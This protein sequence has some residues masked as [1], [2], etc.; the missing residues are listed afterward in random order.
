[1]DY[2]LMQ[3]FDYEKNRYSFWEVNPEFKFTEPFDDYY[4]ATENKDFSSEVMW[5]IFLFCDI[6]SPKIRLRKDE[7]EED[8]KKYFLKDDTFSFEYHQDLID[9]YPKVVMT[10][11]QRELKVWQ[12]K[13]EERNKFLETVSYS[14]DTFEALDKMMKDSKL[15]WE[16]FGKIYKEYQEENIETRA[17]GGRE[18]SFTEKLVSKSKKTN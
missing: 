18:E 17:R 12:D 6:K 16:S 14:L 3:N 5:A 9:A 8:I 13:I 1:M 7:R 2:Y 10:K 4:N 15:I 11:I